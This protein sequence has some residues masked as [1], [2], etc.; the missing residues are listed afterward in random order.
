MLKDRYFQPLSV[1][2]QHSCLK[3]IM[4]VHVRILFIAVVWSVA[5]YALSS[6]IWCMCSGAEVYICKGENVLIAHEHTVCAL[7]IWKEFL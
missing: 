1:K 6:Q 7:V 3:W 4:F 5:P 2:Y